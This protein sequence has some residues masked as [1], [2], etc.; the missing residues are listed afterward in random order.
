MTNIAMVFPICS[1]KFFN[2]PTPCHF[3]YS[4]RPACIIMFLCFWVTAETPPEKWE[5]VLSCGME[6]RLESQQSARILTSGTQREWG[7]SQEFL[8]SYVSLVVTHLTTCTWICFFRPNSY[9]KSKLTTDFS[10]FNQSLQSSFLV[11]MHCWRFGPI[12]R[13][14]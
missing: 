11:I 10:S 12:T 8:H 2:I 6:A 14:R 5:E 9:K 1:W 4:W 7:I 3:S 13:L